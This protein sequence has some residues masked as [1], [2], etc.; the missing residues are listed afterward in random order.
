MY[1]RTLYKCDRVLCEY[2]FE[3]F[4]TK[5]E[6][7]RHCNRHDR[8]F[9][10]LVVNCSVAPF[11]FANKKDCERH[12]RTYHSLHEDGLDAFAIGNGEP[13]DELEG[14]FK[15]SYVYTVERS[16]EA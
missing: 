3:G 1:G 9:H 2:F 8:P 5:E 7:D 10:C 13:V 12:I 6:L 16:A 15:F 4:A 11:G 14:R